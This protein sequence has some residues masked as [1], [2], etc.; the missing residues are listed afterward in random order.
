MRRVRLCFSICTCVV[1]VLVTYALAYCA[2]HL[3]YK[4]M[5]QPFTFNLQSSALFDT[6]AALTSGVAFAILLLISGNMFYYQVQVA[7]DEENPGDSPNG[8]PASAQD[9][10]IEFHLDNESPARRER[11]RSRSPTPQDEGKVFAD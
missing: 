10:R 8:P 6:S 3:Y 7:A 1:F 11:D 2:K 4:E 5:K 9:A